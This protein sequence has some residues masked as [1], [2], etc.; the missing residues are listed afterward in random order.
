MASILPF[1]KYAD[2]RKK[3]IRDGERDSLER[4]HVATNAVEHSSSSAVTKALFK[5]RLGSLSTVHDNLNA[6]TFDDVKPRQL[7]E[8]G[9]E[10]EKRW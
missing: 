2:R 4:E 1:W 10:R 3:L 5:R 9:Q 8:G 7:P 6:E